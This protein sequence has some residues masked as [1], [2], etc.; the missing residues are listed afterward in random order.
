MNRTAKFDDLQIDFDE[1]ERRKAA[2]VAKLDAVIDYARAPG[3][4]QKVVLD[5]FGDPDACDCGRCDRC[6]P[7]A[8]VHPRRRPPTR[9]WS[10]HAHHPGRCDV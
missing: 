3:C 10:G 8:D 5:Y 1:L 9:Q 2:E 4:R 6:R 7:E